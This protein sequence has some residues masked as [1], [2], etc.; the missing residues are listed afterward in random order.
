MTEN[1]NSTQNKDKNKKKQNLLKQ[2]L[3]PNI[4]DIIETIFGILFIFSGANF[5]GRITPNLYKKEKKNKKRLLLEI[6]FVI[7]VIIAVVTA[8]MSIRVK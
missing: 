8:E 4:N 3:I 7:F 1:D 6:L 5:M 2:S